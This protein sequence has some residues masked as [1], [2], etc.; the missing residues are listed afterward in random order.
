MISVRVC[1]R[2]KSARPEYQNFAGSS[3]KKNAWYRR[4]R[5]WLLYTVVHQ[6]QSIQLALSRS[7]MWQSR[8]RAFL[9]ISYRTTRILA[10]YRIFSLICWNHYRQQ[11]KRAFE[12]LFFGKSPNIIDQFI[13]SHTLTLHSLRL[14][15][16]FIKCPVWFTRYSWLH[17][18]YIYTL[19]RHINISRLISSDCQYNV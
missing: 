14:M 4:D 2:L 11:A 6:F 12:L 15:Y 13:I 9:T 5:A 3:R 16:F 8:Y 19:I 7:H 1:A 18:T 10:F 17:F